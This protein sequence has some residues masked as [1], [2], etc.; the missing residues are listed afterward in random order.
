MLNTIETSYPFTAKQGQITISTTKNE[1]RSLSS[2]LI[3]HQINVKVD[4]GKISIDFNYLVS[5]FIRSEFE[6]YDN[7]KAYIGKFTGKIISLEIP[8]LG[9][10]EIVAKLESKGL[11][12]LFEKLCSSSNSP[13]T[14][15]NYKIIEDFVTEILPNLIS[16]IKNG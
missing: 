1:T 16:N 9:N 12:K 14:I 3:P 15:Q 6:R 11:G 7:I 8:R 2:A 5:E 13:A 4:S 10:E